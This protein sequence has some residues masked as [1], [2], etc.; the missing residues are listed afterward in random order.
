MKNPPFKSTS[1]LLADPE[2]TATLDPDGELD[3]SRGSVAEQSGGDGVDSHR[4]LPR[5]F[6][7]EN[8]E[9]LRRRG[10]LMVNTV[11]IR[12]LDASAGQAQV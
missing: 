4:R 6:R 7:D 10:G 8:E 2:P 5:W 1:F 12:E 9:A 11:A 3:R